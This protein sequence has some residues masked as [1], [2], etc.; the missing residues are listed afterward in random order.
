MSGFL[1]VD[2]ARVKTLFAEGFIQ[3]EEV[4]N[5]LIELGYKLHDGYYR[6]LSPQEDAY[7]CEFLQMYDNAF[8]GW[9]Y[10]LEEAL[11]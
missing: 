7:L 4:D 3:A 5:R 1:P 2:Y 11:R 9:S 8:P 6:P 10:T